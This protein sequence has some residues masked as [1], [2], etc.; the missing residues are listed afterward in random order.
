MKPLFLK[1][2][3]LVTKEKRFPL[4]PGIRRREWMVENP[5]SFKCY[6]ITNSNSFGWDLL[7]SEDIKVVWNGNKKGEDIDIIQ[8]K[9]IAKSTF[10]FGILTLVPGYT[11]HTSPN[12]SLQF[13]PIPNYD[14][15]SFEPISALVETCS[16]KYP[17]FISIKM[18]KVGETFIPAKTPICRVLPIHVG[19]V[20]ACQPEIITEPTDFLEYRDWQSK[21]R[22]EFLKDPERKKKE[23]G[24]QK[25]YVKVAERLTLRVKNV[26]DNSMKLHFRELSNVKQKEENN[27]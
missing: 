19:P 27:G 25:F 24:W 10:G 26:V 8:G 16:L 6:P 23:K 14:H 3:P 12:W 2:Y 7:T 11:W 20:I 1:L 18:K 5:H 9:D 4:E 17:I 13:T 15:V 21:E 22:T